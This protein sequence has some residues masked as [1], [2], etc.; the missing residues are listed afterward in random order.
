MP[1]N[2]LIILS[3]PRSFSSVVST[4][5]GQHPQIYCFPELHLFVGETIGQILDREQKKGNYGGPPG[6]L[7]ALAQLHDGIQTTTTII[8]A[9]A[10]LIERRDWSVKQLIDHLLLL[11]TPRIGVEKSPV[12]CMS[13][14]FLANA[15]ACYPN[16]YYLHLTR[17]PVSTRHSMQ[18]FFA[19]RSSL[20]DSKVGKGRA[21][22]FDHLL[23]WY[24]MH[25]N[26]FAFTSRLPEAQVMRL[27]GED[28]L[29]DPDLYLPQIAE[30]LG[31]RTDREAIE[32]M[33]H[34]ERSPYACVG[35][36]P[37]RGGNDGKFMRGPALRQG[38][39]KEPILKEFL[40]NSNIDWLSREGI[41]LLGASGLQMTAG[42]QIGAEIEGMAQRMGYQ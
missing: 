4:M 12:T 35:P 19:K 34:P 5:I 3:P 15:Y 28:L 37:A 30:W 1:P 38:K 14:S 39:V 21:L 24:R 23:M 33:K 32:E 25:R 41:A 13:P 6:T 29:S 7:R 22:K 36:A 16:A 2:M 9:T 17:H 40:S 27:K 11:I 20:S 18:E 42:P 8:R 31:V 26:I 10:W